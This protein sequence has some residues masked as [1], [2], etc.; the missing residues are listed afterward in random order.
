ML[1][2]I[3]AD[4]HGLFHYTNAGR[5]SWHGFAQAIL[6]EAAALG[7]AVETRLVEPIPTSAYPTAATRPAFSVLDTGKIEGWLALA[8]PGWR[9]SLVNMLEELRTCADCL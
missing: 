5:T 8:I 3:G 9:D 6:D 2:L 1:Q 4:A 7:F